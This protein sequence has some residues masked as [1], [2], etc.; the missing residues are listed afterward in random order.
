MLLPSLASISEMNYL[1]SRQLCEGFRILLLCFLLFSAPGHVAAMVDV[2]LV[3]LL[4]LGAFGVERGGHLGWA[5]GG[6]H[7]GSGLGRV[8]L[9]ITDFLLYF[10]RRLSRCF[11]VPL[12]Q[13]ADRLVTLHRS[14]ELTLTVAR[15]PRLLGFLVAGRG[16]L[17]F[18]LDGRVGSRPDDS[19]GVS[20]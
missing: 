14:L 11:L 16:P 9:R 17:L 1:T 2:G 6:L 13:V 7:V 4:T 20:L 18:V 5:G 8:V 15:I 10:L 3:D 12:H 19:V